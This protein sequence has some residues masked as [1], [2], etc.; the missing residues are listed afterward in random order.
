LGKLGNTE[1]REKP[2]FLA[3]MEDVSDTLFRLTCKEYGADFLYTEFISS[4]AL[5]RDVNRTVKKM[6]ITESERPIGIQIYGNITSSMVNAATIAEELKPDLI[7]INFGCPVKKIANRGGGSGML[8][9]IPKLL[10]ITS[11]IVK[12]VKL[13]VTVKT[14]L[15]WDENSKVIV[16]LSE[17][18]QD[19]GIQG[20]TIHGRTRAQMYTGE[21]DWTLIGQIKNNPRIK[22][23]IIGNGDIDS[24]EKAASMFDRYGVDGIMIG[25]GSIGNPHIFKEV[26]HYLETGEKLPPLT[27]TEQLEQLRKLVNSSVSLKGLPGGIL[28]MRR[29]MA[30]NFNGLENF[31]DLRIRMLR[32]D[33]PQKL[34]LIFDEIRDRY[35]DR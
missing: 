9:D 34:N 14:R 12:T 28:H 25:R 4:E 20:L 17:Q 35:G 27:L 19:C 13:P 15:G 26:R 21:A 7:D 1:L 5:I 22:I 24:P 8:R 30:K 32:C 23:P 3:P 11:E 33:D 31:R 2:L 29:H 18:L 6:K 16:D 10:E